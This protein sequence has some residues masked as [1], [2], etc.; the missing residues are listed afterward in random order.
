MYGSE[1]GESGNCPPYRDLLVF[2]EKIKHLTRSE[3]ELCQGV[4]DCASIPMLPMVLQLPINPYA[5]RPLH[6]RA[7]SRVPSKTPLAA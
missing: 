6:I 1:R 4:E 7:N 5:K 2:L 3:V